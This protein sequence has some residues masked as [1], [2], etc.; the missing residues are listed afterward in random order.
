MKNIKYLFLLF[1]MAITFTNCDSFLEDEL[2]DYQEF[3]GDAYGILPE[4][5]R[6]NNSVY[7]LLDPDNSIVDFS[8]SAL[9]S[10]GSVA[11]SGEIHSALNDGS[12]SKVSDIDGFPFNVSLSLTQVV[13][14]LG[15][16]TSSLTGGDLVHFK[17][18]FTDTN[19]NK[20]TSA[21]IFT[22]AIVCPPYS[23]TYTIYMQ[24]S[25]GDG[26]QGGKVNANLDG[27]TTSFTFDAGGACCDAHDDVATYNVPVGATALVWSY[28]NDSWNGEVSF[29]IE[30]P[31]GTIIH[32]SSSPPVA[33]VLS[34]PSTCPD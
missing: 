17:V 21:T 29:Q 32:N 22:A 9:E 28:S 13:T 20:M 2:R 7:N 15:T 6:G 5:V 34:V 31:N 30:D 11:K 12:F 24:D 16:T 33:G 23:G 3:R 18:F 19:E 4:Y 26:W 1:A 8:V 10:G 27:V 14:G 25:Y